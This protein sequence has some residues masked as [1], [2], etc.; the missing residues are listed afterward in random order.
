MA[1]GRPAL[2]FLLG[3]AVLAAE[4]SAADLKLERKL[5]PKVLHDV[6]AGAG[7]PKVGE[8][9]GEAP[10]QAHSAEFLRWAD[11]YGKESEYCDEGKL[12]CA[13]SLRRV[14]LA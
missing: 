6:D 8:K 4:A 12:P 2:L 1:T 10:E 5:D 13:E 11:K 9:V 14:G 3:L 7:I